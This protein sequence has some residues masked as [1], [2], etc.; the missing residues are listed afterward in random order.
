MLASLEHCHV[1]SDLGGAVQISYHFMNSLA[2]PV[3]NK[4]LKTVIR[5]VNGGNW[6]N[7]K[8]SHLANTINLIRKKRLDHIITF[9]G[10]AIF[11]N[12]NNRTFMIVKEQKKMPK[13]PI[14][15][16]DAV[17]FHN[18]RVTLVKL[19]D[20]WEHADYPSPSTRTTSNF[21]VRNLNS[22]DLPLVH[23]GIHKVKRTPI[24]HMC[25]RNLPIIVDEKGNHV[26]IPTFKFVDRSYGVTCSF[27]FLPPK[28]LHEIV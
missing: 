20:N 3:A 19:R 15:V 4:L 5:F 25:L 12:E 13:V 18:L 24:P 27:S 14:K 11:P 23:F 22:G 17:M 8:L 16:N 1:K 28:M 26:A 2:P 10:A 7:T 9:G 6:T 21:F